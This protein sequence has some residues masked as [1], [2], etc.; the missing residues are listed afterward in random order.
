MAASARRRRAESIQAGGPP[1]LPG[2]RRAAHPPPAMMKQ[3]SLGGLGSRTLGRMAATAENGALAAVLAMALVLPVAGMLLRLAGFGGLPGASVLVQHATLWIGMIGGASA[4]RDGRLLAFT[5]ITA[6]LRGRWKTAPGVLAG[7]AAAG[8]AAVLAQASWVFVASERAGGNLLVFALP[9]WVAE[10]ALPAGFGLIAIRLVWTS[11]GNWRTRL[12]AA[13]LA[14]AVLA[15]AFGLGG[16]QGGLAVWAGIGAVLLAGAAGMPIFAIIGGVTLVLLWGGGLPFATVPLKHYALTTNPTLPM[17]PLFALAGY[18]LAEGGASARLVRVFQAWV[19]GLRGGPAV[20]AT[21]VCAFFTTFT[22]ASGVT[23][24]ALGSLLLSVLVAAR[25]RER[26]ALGLLTCSGALGLLFPPCLPLILYAII[27]GNTLVNLH[28]GGTGFVGVS[29]EQMFLAGIV[30]GVLLVVLT[31]AWGIWKSPAGP[32]ERAPFSLREAGAAL[33]ET[34]WEL[35][36]PGVALAAFFGGF[37]SP[38]EAAALTAL[39]A[40]LIEWLAYRDLR[41]RRDFLR[42]TTECGLLVGG[43]LLIL[44]VAMGFT[45]WLV[46][47]QVPSQAVEWA[48]AHLHAKWIFLLLLNGFL[49]IVGCLMDIFSATVVVVPLILP[50]A[51][52]FGVSPIHLGIV[53]LANLEL[54][55]LTPPVGMNLFLAAY[56]FNRP[57]VEIIRAVSGIFWWRLAAVL[58]LTYVP[59]L[60]TWLPSF[61][62]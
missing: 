27:A 51:L 24:L 8:I 34:K 19:G 14:A 1:A 56:R 5:G 26:D 7:G 36:L 43:V 39:Y 20:V 48:T 16:G 38:V 42:I 12:G 41:L 9:T 52:A 23:I 31:A 61:Y 58:A 47:A 33:W 57:I 32:A 29:M 37:A 49:L 30:P 44:G 45:H 17:V 11:G 21:C 50:I 40:L 55:Y 2:C 46:M 13:T 53:F 54:G 62:R 18:F 60:S 6:F 35:A 3:R 25:M 59:W 4:A 15:A 10:L 28:P 22:G